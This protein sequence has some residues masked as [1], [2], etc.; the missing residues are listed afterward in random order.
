MDPYVSAVL[1]GI[2]TRAWAE[3]RIHRAQQDAEEVACVVEAEW[4]DVTMVDRLLAARGNH[5]ELTCRDGVVLRGICT[6]VGADWLS[7]RGHTH[8]A[9]HIAQIAHVAGAPSALHHEDM[10][11]M[12]WTAFLRT[13]A[14]RQI[15]V[16]A[17]HGFLSGRLHHVARDHITFEDGRLIALQVILSVRRA[18]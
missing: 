11:R 17:H 5:I 10:R 15:L 14:G 18:G 16:R 6:D 12:T 3:G 2:E 8:D 7:I 4:A 1:L 9:V 13:L